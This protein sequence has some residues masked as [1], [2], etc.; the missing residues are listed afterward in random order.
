MSQLRALTS[1]RGEQK[2]RTRQHLL[3]AALRLMDERRGFASLS[4]REV[5]KEAGVVPAAFYRHFESLDQLGLA[6]VEECGVTLRRLL[7][8]ARRKGLQPRQIL[9]SSVE[10]YHAH[11]LQHRLHFLFAASAR[12]GTPEIRKALRIEESHFANEMAQDMRD[13][14]LLPSMPKD[15]LQMICRLVV[16]TMMH[17]ATEILDLPANDPRQERELIDNFVR[18]LRLIFIGARSWQSKD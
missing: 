11:V 2:Q 15:D 4:L 12:G 16:T 3:D 8:E 14:G 18:Q 1:A 13:L 7:R 6:L 5:A 17:A 10:I 9:R